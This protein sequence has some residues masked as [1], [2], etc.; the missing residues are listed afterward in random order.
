MLGPAVRRRD[1]ALDQ[2]REDRADR[3][4]GRPLPPRRRS[5]H[6]VRRGRRTRRAR[7]AATTWI[8]SPTPS[9]PPTGAATTTSPSRS[10]SR[11]R[12]SASRCRAGSSS[13]PAPGGTSATIGRYLRYRR[14]D[15]LL[16]VVDPENSAF[17]PG[18]RDAIRTRRPAC[19]SR[20]EGIGR[21]RVEP[22][23]VPGVVDRMI[24]GARRRVDRDVAGR[25]AGPRAAGRALDG[26]E[27]VGRAAHRRARCAAE[28]V[29]AAS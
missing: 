26:H 7:R 17:F 12:W 20:I 11:W 21:P 2:R 23:F 22:S 25:R 19:G 4:R 1:A 5:D 24:A 3:A 16:A 13:A 29:A 27:P 10:S 14:H 18:W 28:R 8:S 6:R 15:T 9:V